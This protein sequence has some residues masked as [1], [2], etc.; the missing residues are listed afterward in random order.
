MYDCCT[1][2]NKSQFVSGLVCRSVRSRVAGS[3]HLKT[4]TT[5]TSTA[6]GHG[7][8][9]RE[10]GDLPKSATMTQGANDVRK[11]DEI[12]IKI[13]QQKRHEAE[14]KRSATV[15]LADSDW[16]GD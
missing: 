7:L 10:N 16:D 4:T 14:V 3:V 11:M 5:T 6:F 1:S 12:D 9:S 2:P 8:S 13:L 15:I